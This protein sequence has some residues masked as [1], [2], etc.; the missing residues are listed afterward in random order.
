MVEE[1]IDRWEG[2]G[3]AREANKKR[4]RSGVIGYVMMNCIVSGLKCVSP[5]SLETSHLVLRPLKV[6]GICQ[7]H[8]VDV[9]AVLTRNWSD[10]LN[11]FW[12]VSGWI[13]SQ[14]YSVATTRL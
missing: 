10:R 5:L 2:K 3:D 8:S 13:I 6:L 12:V 4:W 14:R 7:D 1:E 9:L 11:R